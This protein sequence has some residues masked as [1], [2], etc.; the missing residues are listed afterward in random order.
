MDSVTL[1]RLYGLEEMLDY[2]MLAGE[3]EEDIGPLLDLV[4]DELTWKIHWFVADANR[5]QPASRVWVRSDCIKQVQEAKKRITLTIV[6]GEIMNSPK[7][8]RQGLM[9]KTVPACLLSDY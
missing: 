2:H 9:A 1:P 4:I 3:E 7:I 8:N 5:W 6:R